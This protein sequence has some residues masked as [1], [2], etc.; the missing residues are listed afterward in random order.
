MEQRHINEKKY[1]ETHKP[2]NELRR[3]R[4]GIASLRSFLGTLQYKHIRGEFPGLVQEIRNH[5]NACRSKLD[6]L[7][8]SRQT[9]AQ[10]RQ[11][12]TRL[13]AR[14]QRRATDSLSGHYDSALES[15]HSLKLRMHLQNANQSFGKSIERNGHTIPFNLVNGKIDESF[16]R[17]IIEDDIYDWIRRQYRESRGAELP[18]TVNPTLLESLFRQQSAKWEPLAEDHLAAVESIVRNFNQALL[19]SLIP[20]DALRSKIEARNLI[21]FN[22]AHIT[23]VK[24]L[25][26]ILAD[27]R[28]GI[29][30]T[31]N[32]YFADTLAKI[33]EDRVLERLKMVG[34]EDGEVREI[35]LGAVMRAAHLS[36]EDQAVNDIHDILKAY[37][38]VALKR[39]M[40]NVI[41]QV[42]ERIYLGSDGPVKAINPEYAGML[43][44]SELSDIAAESY[45]TSTTRTE[46]GY[47]LERL[48]KALTLAETHLI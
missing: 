3:D 29:L 11:F 40:D 41:L 16:E 33:R 12:V 47:K 39:F 28:G 10:Q 13:A 19:A 4:V 21:F 27:E 25:Q 46:I 36:N 37:Y 43:S 26:Q 30:Q 44:D 20:E 5:V 18:G 9:F 14:Y 7:G 1:F 24:Q 38:K 45:A 8:P 32:H 23:A 6:A 17:G 31:I 48:E 15:Q 2:F 42:V 34:L 35:D 22:A